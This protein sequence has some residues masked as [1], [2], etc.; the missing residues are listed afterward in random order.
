VKIYLNNQELNYA[1]ENEKTV[2]DVVDSIENWLKQSQM[3]IVQLDLDG[4]NYTYDEIKKN[5]NLKLDAVKKMDIQVKPIQE[6]NLYQI[7]KLLAYFQELNN[8]IEKRDSGGI[9]QK[10]K[11]FNS[12]CAELATIL[13]VHSTGNSYSEIDPLTKIFA[14]TT[15]GMI[16]SWTALNRKEASGVLFAV[17]SKLKLLKNEIEN[18]VPILAEVMEKLSIA[19]QNISQVSVLLQT[20]KDREAMQAIVN[21]SELTQSLLRILSHAQFAPLLQDISFKEKSYT[22]FYTDFNMHLHEIITAFE[23]KDYVLLGD[24]LEYEIAP[25]IEEILA[26]SLKIKKQAEKN[27]TTK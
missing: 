23:K 10:L 24:L 15:S 17:I 3:M 13:G 27:P 9:E 1:L 14:G 25:A 20:G 2:I 18:P 21:F 12:I 8:C 22:E 16:D 7:S 4:K 19:K 11:D 5:Q 26:S 6:F